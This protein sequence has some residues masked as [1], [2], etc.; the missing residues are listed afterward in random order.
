L[1]AW[2]TAARSMAGRPDSW[3]GQPLGPNQRQTIY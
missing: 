1:V 2:S 3:V